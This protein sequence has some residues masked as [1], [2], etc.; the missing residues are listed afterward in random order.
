MTGTT[1]IITTLSSRRPDLSRIVEREKE[2]DLK[3]QRYR[4][5]GRERRKDRGLKNRP[6]I[7]L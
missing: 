2:A 4:K 6:S 7:P 1:A 3:D 5:E